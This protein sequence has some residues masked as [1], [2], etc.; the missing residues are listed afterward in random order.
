MRLPGAFEQPPKL[1]VVIADADANAGR[2]PIQS[3]V[4]LTAQEKSLP[5]A[6]KF[7]LFLSD[8]LNL[9]PSTLKE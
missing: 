5:A 6:L 8:S 4:A 1:M 2:T 9:R 7:C 3:R